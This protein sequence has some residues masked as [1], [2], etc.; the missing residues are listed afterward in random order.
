MRRVIFHWAACFSLRQDGRMAS[1]NRS[2]HSPNV[3]PSVGLLAALGLL[4]SAS[5]DRALWQRLVVQSEGGIDVICSAALAGSAGAPPDRLTQ[6]LTV[7]KPFYR[8]IVLDMGRLNS[9]APE[10]LE[11]LHEIRLIKSRDHYKIK[12][13][14][15]TAIR[16]AGSVLILRC[17]ARRSRSAGPS[18]FY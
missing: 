17:K 11:A 12:A 3:A 4:P 15:D 10:L 18:S 16:K 1:I 13:I 7:I 9:C 5:L 6:V 8:W 2:A 14:V